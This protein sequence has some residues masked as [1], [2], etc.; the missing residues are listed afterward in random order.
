MCGI[1]VDFDGDMDLSDDY[2]SQELMDD[3]DEMDDEE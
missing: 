1:D 2:L 3:E